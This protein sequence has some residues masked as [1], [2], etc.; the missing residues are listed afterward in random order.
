MLPEFESMFL[1]HHIEINQLKYIRLKFTVPNVQFIQ[2]MF[3]LQCGN[4]AREG[5]RTLVVARKILTEEQYQEF[6][7]LLDVFY[8]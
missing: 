7:V 5:L 8:L 1:F 6:Q 4:L 2:Y 3:S